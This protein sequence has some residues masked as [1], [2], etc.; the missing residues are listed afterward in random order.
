MIKAKR[1]SRNM[2]NVLVAMAILLL[3]LLGLWLVHH[4][5]TSPRREYFQD[6]SPSTK[7]VVNYY[8]LENCRF[9]LEFDPEWQKFVTMSANKNI[10][11]KKIDGTTQERYKSFPTIEIIEKDAQPREYTGNRTAIALMDH[12]N[13]AE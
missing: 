6:A 8:Y 3:I 11:T 5:L 7:T 1:G 2:N 12:L 9:C 13:S 4:F 10:E